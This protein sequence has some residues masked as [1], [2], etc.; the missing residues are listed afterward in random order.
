MS[1]PNYVEGFTIGLIQGVTELFPVSSLGHSVLIPALIG[2]SWARDLDMTAKQSPYLAF[3]VALH[4]ATALG[5]MIYFRR[6][7]VRI[8]RGLY[9]VVRTRRVE[10]ADE[11]LAMLLIIGTIPVAI[12]GLLFDSLLREHVGKP[13]PAALFLVINGLVLL[14]VERMR[15]GG[16]GGGGGSRGSR[17]AR[18]RRRPRGN[19]VVDHDLRGRPLPADI[20]SDVRLARVSVRDVLVIGGTQS[21]GLLPGI[22]RSGVTISAGLLKG[23]R[24]DDAARL[25]FLLATPVI[26]AAAVLKLPEL[27]KPENHS[28]LGPAVL[29]GLVALVASFLST[30]FLA[31]YFENRNMAPF[32]LY[33]MVA[34]VLAL[35]YFGL[36]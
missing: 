4:V 32:A 19:D 29:G 16:G 8:I 6:D 11:R 23:L 2:G 26:L 5:M 21:F 20:A 14:G 1:G 31:R 15:A 22:S 7:W 35:A 24:H 10:T 30:R 3:L 33:C 13:V 34:G 12:V 28:V 25:A 18:G 9:F 36:H 17:S 27:A